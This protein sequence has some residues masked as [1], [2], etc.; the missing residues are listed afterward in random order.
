MDLKTALTLVAVVLA[1]IPV[2]PVDATR[3]HKEFDVPAIF[4]FGDSLG[5]AGTNSF[6]PQATARADFPPYGKT[7]F[8]KPTGRFTNGRTIVDFI[9]QKLDLP[10]TPPFLEP[11]ASFTKGV[12]FASG[13]SGLLD[14]TSADDF[15]VPMSAQVQQFAIAKATLEKQLDAHRAGSLISKSIFLFIS[16]SNDLSA[17]LRDAQL[18]QQ[19]NATQFVASLIDVYQKS[20]LAVYHAGARKA[21]VVGVGPLGCSPLARASNTAN[22]GE[23]VEVANQLALGFNAALK[24]MVDGLRAALP[25]F[26]LVL[27]NT[28]DTVSAMITDGKA[29]GLD[30]VTAACCGAGFLNAQ[31]QCGKPVPPSLPGAVQDFC[32]RPFKSLFWDVLHPTEHVVRILFNMLFTGDATAAYPINLRALAQL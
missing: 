19:V 24:Q 2:V 31:V 30:N 13:G 32:R 22:P 17:F 14:S 1:A 25:G 8:R 28:F 21:I 23:C 12:N 26:N 10:L 20:L 6:I 7:F 5:D 4:A 16:G 15:S 29:F 18:Q 9:A 27:A 11:H 3:A